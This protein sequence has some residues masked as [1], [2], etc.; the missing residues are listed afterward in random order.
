MVKKFDQICQAMPNGPDYGWWFCHGT[1]TPI[2]Q[3]EEI[4]SKYGSTP[5]TFDVFESCNLS[6]NIKLIDV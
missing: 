5:I 1:E 2:I 4:L 3:H 6:F